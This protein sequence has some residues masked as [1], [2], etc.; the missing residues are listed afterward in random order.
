MLFNSFAFLLFFP[1]V[2]TGY[3]LLPHRFRWM[4]LLAA[5]CYFY[6]SFVPVYILILAFTIGVDYIAGLL[7]ERAKGERK[8]MYLVASILANV[9]VL[10]IFKYY[11][12]F[13][14]NATVLLNW[15]GAPVPIPYLSILLPI[16][17]SFHTFQAM[18]Y[19][20]EVYRGNQKAVRHFGIYALYVMFYPQLVAGP[21]ERPQN[22]LHQFVEPHTVDGTRVRSGLHRMLWGFFK[23]I[24]IAD[25]LAVLVA[26]VY[27][28]PTSFTGIPLIVATIAFSVQLYCDFSGYS[29]IALGSARVMG[30]RLMENF[31]RPYGSPSIMEFWKRWHI[32]LTTWFRDYLYLPLARRHGTRA[33]FALVTVFVF[34]VSGLWHG[35]NW[36]FVIWGGLH[37]FFMVISLVSKQLRDRIVSF[38]RLSS[39]P[40]IHRAIRVV[41]TFSLVTFSFIFFR[42]EHVSHAW[43]IVTHLFV[44]IGDQI[45]HIGATFASLGI[46]PLVWG[47]V[48]IGCVMVIT[49]E[50]FERAHDFGDRI[51]QLPYGFRWSTYQLL[52]LCILFF[53]YFGEQP[54]IYFQF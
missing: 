15:F 18:S 51:R 26:H 31:R 36:T 7:I 50:W 35:A 42:A 17:L 38:F 24:V 33:W 40:R 22:L 41:I 16:G 29:D 11:N 54:F 23:K 19:T 46:S 47:S 32:S 8:K 53:G 3:F 25:N 21:I 34:L 45:S 14:D 20:I 5:S 13:V 30:F 28:H 12:F 10:A 39:F 1:I 44:G 43:Y 4:W 2:T 6:M 48:L 27:G 37:G 52:L 49:M 9:G